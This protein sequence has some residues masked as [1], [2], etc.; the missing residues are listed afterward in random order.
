MSSSASWVE[1]MGL[2]SGCRTA[3]LG[4]AF[5]LLMQGASILRKCPV[6]PVSAILVAGGEEPIVAALT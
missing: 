5:R 3:M 4:L 6:V 1:Y 2:P